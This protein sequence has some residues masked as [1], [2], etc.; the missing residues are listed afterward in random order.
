M[1]RCSSADLAM[2]CPASV[3]YALHHPE[4]RVENESLNR[5]IKPMYRAFG[6]IVHYDIQVGLGCSGLEEPTDDDR[7]EAQPMEDAIERCVHGGITRVKDAYGDVRWE[8]ETAFRGAN[9]KGH[10]DLF[11]DTTL[12]DFKTTSKVPAR[13]QIAIAHY[14]QLLAYH[15][16]TGRTDLRILYIQSKGDWVS[17]SDPIDIENS[18]VKRDIEALKHRME[19]PEDIRVYGSSCT[20]CNFVDACRNVAIPSIEDPTEIKLEP[21]R[22]A[23]MEALGLG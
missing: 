12:I 5:I 3:F 4:L 9:L 6:T 16:L 15:V 14:W 17:M 7:I 11:N 21:V 10:P 22:S 1:V 8:A 19:H 18:V 13:K 20:K 2:A 23:A